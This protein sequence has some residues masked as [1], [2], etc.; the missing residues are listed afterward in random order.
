MG[1]ININIY[2]KKASHLTSNINIYAKSRRDMD[3]AGIEREMFAI[4]EF[5]HVKLNGV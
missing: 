5:F 2:V 3:H 1:N 4:N